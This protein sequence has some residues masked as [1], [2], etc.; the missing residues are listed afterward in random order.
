M[1]SKLPLASRA[2]CD[3][4]A[5]HYLAPF[6]ARE[7]TLTG[8]CEALRVTPQ[9][10]SYWIAKLLKLGLLEF[11][12]YEKQSRHRRA[13]YRSVEDAYTVP[14]SALDDADLA[15]LMTST[16]SVRFKQLQL[17]MLRNLRR[18]RRRLQLRL[19]HDGSGP[20]EA[21]ENPHAPDDYFGTANETYPLF[22]EAN[23]VK[24]L[25]SD[26]RILLAKYYALSQRTKPAPVMLY[27]GLAEDPIWGTQV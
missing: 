12:R 1:T 22:L 19:W 27:I 6:L 17:S 3:Y 2:L 14:L 11:V 13:M 18:H 5:R 25:H 15:R 23:E 10:M 24:Q 4:R 21:I 8:A 16:Q 9:R 7:N 26:L 20:F